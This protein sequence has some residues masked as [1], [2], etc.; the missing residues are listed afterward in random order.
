MEASK[1]EF[2]NQN[3]LAE[4]RRRK[5]NCLQLIILKPSVARAARAYTGLSHI[6][7]AKL[8]GVAPRTISRLENEGNVSDKAL[9]KIL[10][11]FTEKGII[12]E[13]DQWGR[14]VGMKFPMQ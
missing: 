9:A 6:G 13:Y 1:S 12:W 10:G 8:A 4:P 11:A 2:R 3:D 7:F 5:S 14:M